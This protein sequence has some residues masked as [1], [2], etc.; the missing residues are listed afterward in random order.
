MKLTACGEGIEEA[1]ICELSLG[2]IVA[3][4]SVSLKENFCYESF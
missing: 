2:V 1:A 3:E 4:I